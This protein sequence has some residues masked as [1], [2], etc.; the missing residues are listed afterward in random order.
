MVKEAAGRSYGK[1]RYEVLDPRVAKTVSQVIGNMGVSLKEYA[2]FANF[3]FRTELERTRTVKNR[4][5]ILFV[6][7]ELLDLK[8]LYLVERWLTPKRLFD[9]Y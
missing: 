5:T 9:H 6:K 7:R 1:N 8:P 4:E 3:N 2:V